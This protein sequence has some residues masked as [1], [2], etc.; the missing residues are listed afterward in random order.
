AFDLKTGRLLWNKAL[1]TALR[2]GPLEIESRLP[3][4]MGAPNLG[5]SIATGGG[6]V[7]V[8][9]AQDRFLRAFDI[10][11]GEE[12]WR[13]PLPSVAAATPMTFVS[14]ASGRQFVVIASGGHPALPGPLGGTILAFALPRN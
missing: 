6:V 10:G 7:F 3:L 9:A 1:G 4:P 14:R 5:G 8:G 12:L 2:A 13:Y 11:N